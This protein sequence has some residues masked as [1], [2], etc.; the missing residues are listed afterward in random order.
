MPRS[1]QRPSRRCAGSVRSAARGRGGPRKGGGAVARRSSLAEPRRCGA[2]CSRCP[3]TGGASCNTSGAAVRPGPRARALAAFG[4]PVAFVLSARRPPFPTTCARQREFAYSH[5]NTEGRAEPGQGGSA[6]RSDTTGHLPSR[7]AGPRGPTLRAVRSDRVGAQLGTRGRF[8][9]SRRSACRHT[10]ARPRP[11]APPRDR[12]RTNTTERDR[13]RRTR[14]RA[15]R[16]LVDTNR[17]R[18]EP[19]PTRTDHRPSHA[20]PHTPTR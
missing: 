10:Q 17:F 11:T 20:D 9:S 7:S 3:A 13:T 2:A 6:A 5:P 8:A 15:P 14:T 16:R 1:T 19:V 12:A 4:T 18:H